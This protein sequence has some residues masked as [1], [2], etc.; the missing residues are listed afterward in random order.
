[1]N[2]LSP[3]VTLRQVQRILADQGVAIDT[4]Q[5]LVRYNEQSEHSFD[6]HFRLEKGLMRLEWCLGYW[7]EDRVDD[8]DVTVGIYL[9]E[10]KEQKDQD[11][12]TAALEVRWHRDREWA[13]ILEEHTY[14][15]R[16]LRTLLGTAYTDE[17]LATWSAVLDKP[18][19]T[20]E[21][22]EEAAHKKIALL[23]KW[24]VALR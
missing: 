4:A 24:F 16:L 11:E 5:E 3:F 19:V 10:T 21:L 22:S 13:I 20:E 18:T 15:D 14:A 6:G 17:P 7:R 23:A 12:P 1:M 8:A 2:S 9:Y